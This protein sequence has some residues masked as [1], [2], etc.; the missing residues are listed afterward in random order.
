MHVLGCLEDAIGAIENIIT[1]LGDKNLS[2]FVV[3]Y[4]ERCC[5]PFS[6]KLLKS[7]IFRFKVCPTHF[8]PKN[9]TF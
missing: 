9:G 6:I 5:R 7:V 2:E 4:E 1:D 8:K 3:K